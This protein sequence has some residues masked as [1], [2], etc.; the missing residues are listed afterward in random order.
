MEE[1]KL[2]YPARPKVINHWLNRA[3]ERKVEAWVTVSTA[4]HFE[5][6]IL[7]NTAAFGI[8]RGVVTVPEP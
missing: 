3:R 7:T 8:A 1:S 5:N 2:Y 6:T 4:N